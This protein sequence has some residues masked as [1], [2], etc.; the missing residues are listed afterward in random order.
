MASSRRRPSAAQQA[1]VL[2]LKIARDHLRA[3]EGAKQSRRTDGWLTQ[4]R[5]PNADIK[6]ALKW[7]MQRH[8]DLADSD[9]WV[10]RAIDVIVSNVIGTGI[11][12]APIG[13]T[14]A[15]AAAFQ[16]W[17]ASQDCDFYHRTNFYG[18]QELALRTIAVRG[19]VVCGSDWSPRWPAGAWCRCSCS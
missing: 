6:P 2:E 12:G 14:K 8:Q 11:E 18:L 7:L 5:G 3:F 15:F 19:S 4:N 13:G 16:D 10:K 9:P 17:A 1:K